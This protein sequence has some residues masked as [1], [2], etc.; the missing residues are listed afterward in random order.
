MMHQWLYLRDIFLNIK[1]E[2]TEVR[3]FFFP[4]SPNIAY[5][6]CE[7]LKCNDSIYY[8]ETD[9]KNIFYLNYFSITNSHSKI[10]SPTIEP[11]KG[12]S[13]LSD[14][15]SSKRE[16]LVKIY[17]KDKRVI[18]TGTIAGE[19]NSTISLKIF[20]LEKIKPIKAGDQ[21][22]LIE[23]IENDVSIRGMRE[24]KV[25]S[26]DHANGIIEIESNIKLEI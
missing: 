11:I 3:L 14:F 22:N 19:T 26:I 4:L 13:Q 9:L 10:Y 16:T 21:V 24:C 6:S 12:E 15:L 5:A 1:N 7:F 17:T 2:S 8:T 20:D 23:V 18:S 25:S